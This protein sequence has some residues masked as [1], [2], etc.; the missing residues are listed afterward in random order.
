MCGVC[1]ATRRRWIDYADRVVRGGL[2]VAAL[3]WTAAAAIAEPAARQRVLLADPD[4]AL[5]H[6]MEQALAP[7]HFEVVV[8]SVPPAGIE[9]ARRRGAADTAEFVV[10]RD[11]AQLVVY[12]RGRDAMEQRTS[13]AGALDAPSAAGAAL[14]IKTMMRLPPPPPPETPDATS[15]KAEP[16]RAAADRVRV[17]VGAAM[18]SARS[19]ETATTARFALAAQLRPWRASQWR[20]G[21]AGDVGSSTSVSRASFKGTWSE[22]SLVATAGWSLVH[23]GWELEPYVAAGLRRSTLD[24]TEANDARHETAALATARAGAWVRRRYQRWTYGVGLAIDETAQNPTYTRASTPAVVFQVPG[25]AV[26]AGFV[27]AVDR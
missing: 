11:G 3:M 20:F 26:E 19:D 1:A 8:E 23:G 12:D 7:W 4:P 16:P 2:F 18:R 25:W 6:A 15:V 24:G 13:R 21:V 9:S 27:I 5:R 10:W 14:T 22:W 17:Q